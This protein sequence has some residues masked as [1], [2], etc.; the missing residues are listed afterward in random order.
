MVHL[1]R[2]EC[3][4][5]DERHDQCGPERPRTSSHPRSTAFKFWQRTVTMS[6]RSRSIPTTARTTL[7]NNLWEKLRSI[8]VDNQVL[9]NLCR[10]IQNRVDRLFSTRTQ[11]PGVAVRQSLASEG[12]KLHIRIRTAGAHVRAALL[13]S[14]S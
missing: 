10:T 12:V 14:S 4:A 6:T 1:I 13:R 7:R 11:I 5:H 9:A 3:R 2:L 8:R